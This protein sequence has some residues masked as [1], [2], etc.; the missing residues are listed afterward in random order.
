MDFTVYNSFSSSTEEQLKEM[1][2]FAE[3]MNS[4]NH[5]MLISN[6]IIENN[7]FSFVRSRYLQ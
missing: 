4:D 7:L 6:P 2:L 5:K 3:K 1:I